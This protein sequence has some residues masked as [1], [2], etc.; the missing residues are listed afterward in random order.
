[1]SRTNNVF[2]PLTFQLQPFDFTAEK[3]IAASHIDRCR[4]VELVKA[5]ECSQSLEKT[6]RVYEISGALLNWIRFCES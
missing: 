1:M 6:L 2:D 4:V 5:V 3:S